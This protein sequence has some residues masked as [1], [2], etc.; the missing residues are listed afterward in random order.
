MDKLIIAVGQNRTTKIWKNTEITWNELV[1]RLKT[2]TRTPET[3]GEFLNMP[4]SQ[5]DNIKD[6]GGFVGGKLTKG[7]RKSGSVEKR[8][9][10]SLDADFADTDFCDGLELFADYTYCVYSTHKHTSEKPR[11]RLLIP[12]SRPCNSDEYEAVARFVAKD[13]GIDMFDDTTYQP[14]RLMYWPSTSID[15]EYLF[16]CEE[17]KP[18]DVD[19]ILSEYGNWTDVSGWPVSSRTIKSKERALKKQ[20]DPTLKK[21]IIGAFCRTYD[22]ESAISEFLSDV[23]AKCDTEGRYTFINGSSAAGLV[24]YENGKFAYSNHATDPTSGILCNAFDLVRI[25]LFG[26]RDEEA[27]AGTPTIKL[28]SYIAMQEFAAKNEAVR[29]LIH[30]EKMETAKNDFDG[31]Y[32]V[33][34]ENEECNN[35]WVLS[36]AV[37]KNGGYAATID[38]VKK[39][40]TN[41][42]NVRDK[43]ALNEFTQKHRVMGAVPWDS[44]AKE[45]DWTDTDD[46]GLR[47]FM[48]RAY[49]LRGKSIIEDAW[50]LVSKENKYHP[51]RDYFDSLEWDGISRVDTLLIDYLGAEDNDYVRAVTRKSLIAAA[52]RIFVPGIKYDTML[53]LVGPQGCGK[54]QIIKRLG[55][56]WFSDTLTTVQGKEAYEQ[57]QGFWIIEVAELAA[58]KKVEVEAIKHFTAKSEDAYRAAYGRHVETY[59]R[60]CVFIGTTNKYEFLRDMTGNRRFW[61]V[62]VNP[63]K[64]VKNMWEDMDEDTVSQIWAEALELFK[65]G[66]KI[67]FDDE[68]LIM[69][70]KEEQNRHLEESPLAGDIQAYLDKLLP[71]DWK[72]FSLSDRR[73]F[74]QGNDFNTESNIGTIK[75]TR[76]CPMEVW[77]ELF[78]GDKKDLTTAK[79][80]E[81]KDVILKTGEWEQHSSNIR[82]GE[83]YGKQKGFIRKNFVSE[84]D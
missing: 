27:A 37:D 70:A 36:L 14:H 79:S 81:I 82:F 41:D 46:A 40:L 30:N 16:R 25:H 33:E 1:E 8:Y 9:I 76:V 52:A 50:A 71:E 20:E 67:Y 77:C 75:R 73:M 12:L 32:S 13:I 10:I 65:K 22:V 28:P 68:K 15:G 29:L 78:N 11:L 64:A 56:D 59:K 43:I 61:P 35:D 80:K 60:Q 66:E 72:N 38:N 62:D 63:D 26:D 44:G 7:R 55:G 3:Q 51:I 53:V 39:I 45:R 4:K 2:T 74:I 58:M 47:H 6:V 42:L 17:N 57:I 21:G 5:Q 83:L 54:S 19:K 23:Y 31:I 34:K 49:G 69:A 18:L 24:I 84:A 48:E